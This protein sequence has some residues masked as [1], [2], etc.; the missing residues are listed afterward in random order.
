MERLEFAK[1][2]GIDDKILFRD[3][4]KVIIDNATQTVYV[5]YA[6]VTLEYIKNLNGIIEKE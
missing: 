6:S 3:G 5:I 4:Q 2:Y 1:L